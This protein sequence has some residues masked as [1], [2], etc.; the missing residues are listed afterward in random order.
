MA[1]I[2]RA[3]AEAQGLQV[4]EAEPTMGGEDFALYQERVPGCFIWMGTGGTEQWHHPKFTLK[5]EALGISA[6]LF[7][8]TAVQALKALG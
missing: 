2:M 4:V 1:E 6:A 8:E 3:A 5:E 7:A